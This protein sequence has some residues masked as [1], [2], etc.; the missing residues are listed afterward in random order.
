M[1]F[2]LK[3]RNNGEPNIYNFSNI[4]MKK[5]LMMKNSYLNLLN[6]LIS[7]NYKLN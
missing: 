6:N 2:N 4:L 3:K 5:Q 7:L 1:I